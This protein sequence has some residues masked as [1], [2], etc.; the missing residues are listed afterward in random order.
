[1][2]ILLLLIL[3]ATQTVEAQTY[4]VIHVIGKIYD[5]K[6]D[7][8]LKPGAKLAENAELKFES[9][10]ARAAVLGSSRGRYV[11]QRQATQP[12]TGDLVY[13][14]SSVLSPAR[15][16]MSTRA[17]GIN[18]QMD[19]MKK[20]GEGPIALLNNTYQVA[21][22]PSS[23]PTDE[24]KFFYASY[25]FNGEAIN[26]KLEVIEDQ[27][28]FDVKTFYA[29][30]EVPIDPALT[31]DSKLFYYDSDKQESTEITSLEFNIVSDSDL[32]AINDSLGELT[33]EEKEIAILEIVNSM[34]G[35]CSPEQIKAA[36]QNLN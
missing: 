17:G 1:M 23:Y 6:T 4:T 8:Y 22:S 20:F 24:T 26:K 36:I 32:T 27:L 31:S 25:T 9:S 10:N 30:D 3:L 7:T 28:I 12:Q 34:Y 35:K 11:I 14:L 16:K 18:N 13:T 29:V 2:R 33:E 5:D 21:L 19:F 15:G